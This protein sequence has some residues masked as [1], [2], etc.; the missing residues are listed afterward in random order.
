VNDLTAIAELR[1][2][3]EQL[4]TAQLPKLDEER[5]KKFNLNARHGELRRTHECGYRLVRALFRLTAAVPSK[6]PL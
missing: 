2:K 5:A 3:Y 1:H 6:N 4:A